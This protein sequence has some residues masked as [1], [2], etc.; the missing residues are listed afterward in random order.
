[1]FFASY[2]D[3]EYGKKAFFIQTDIVDEVIKYEQMVPVTDHYILDG[4]SL[5]VDQWYNYSS[6]AYDNTLSTVKH[7]T[8]ATLVFDV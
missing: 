7:C 3:V 2:K 5:M 1:M 8:S 4:W 6:I